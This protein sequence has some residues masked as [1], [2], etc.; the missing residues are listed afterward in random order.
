[1]LTEREQ[2]RLTKL[3]DKHLT[4]AK[5]FKA[6]TS[7]KIKEE[8]AKLLAKL[9]KPAT[10]TVE[11]APEPKEPGVLL[12]EN[13]ATAEPEPPAAPVKSKGEIIHDARGPLA[14][15]A[16]LS[17]ASQD[18]RDKVRKLLDAGMIYV[19]TAVNGQIYIKDDQ[20][21]YNV[22]DEKG[23]F[24]PYMLSGLSDYPAPVLLKLLT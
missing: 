10:A 3:H 20:F 22:V 18:V 6:G 23:A 17:R 24:V 16:D 13:T 4:Q 21:L 1:M 7:Q 5:T 14:K 11:D 2:T 19:G 15:L 12:T 9:A 8:I